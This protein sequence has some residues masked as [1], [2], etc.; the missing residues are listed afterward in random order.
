[1]ARGDYDSEPAYLVKVFWDIVDKYLLVQEFA[2]SGYWLPGGRVDPGEP[3][4]EAAIRECKEEA[5]IDIKLK[6]VLTFQFNHSTGRLKAIYYAEPIDEDQK[7]KSIPDYESVGACYVK[8]DELSKLE[9][10]GSEP[11]KW[12]PYVVNGKTIYPLDI[13][14]KE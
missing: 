7:P 4:E 1:M 3:L 14:T 12:I 11:L 2:N 9:L 6:G 13:F 8:H 5:G 10:R